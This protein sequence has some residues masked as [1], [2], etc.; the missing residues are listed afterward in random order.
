METDLVAH[1]ARYHRRSGPKPSHVEYVALRREQRVVVNKLA[2]ILRVADAM[3]RGR[4]YPARSLRL[5]RE[6][7]DL[8]IHV[9]GATDLIL[10]KRALA[11]K[12]DLF[13]DIYGMRV[14]LEEA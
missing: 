9:P 14:R 1:V 6:G 2:A 12:G 3:S 5:E 10:E 4:P 8:I 13:E 7:D 11:I